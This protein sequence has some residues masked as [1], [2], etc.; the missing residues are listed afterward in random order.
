MT[1][2]R[3]ARGSRVVVVRA[4]ILLSAAKQ[5]CRNP[6]HTSASGARHSLSRRAAPRSRACSSSTSR[7]PGSTRT[8]RTTSCCCSSGSRAAATASRGAPS[9]RRSTRPR[10]SRS[11]ASTT[12]RCSRPA[13]TSTRAR[14]G[15]ERVARGDGC[16]LVPVRMCGRRGAAR[17]AAR[18]RGAQRWSVAWC[19]AMVVFGS[20]E[21][22]WPAR[23]SGRVV[24]RVGLRV[25]IAFALSM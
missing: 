21:M 14:R 2:R 18:R 24:R 25:H 1:T 11:A 5:A 12:S 10:R 19:V 22:E 7:R 23:C 17:R 20:G 3:R 8:R 4:P 15:R 6:T 16:C 9:V 13:A